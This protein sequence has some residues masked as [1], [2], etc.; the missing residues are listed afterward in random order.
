MQDGRVP[1]RMKIE[2][3]AM[4]F[5]VKSLPGCPVHTTTSAASKRVAPVVDRPEHGTPS[6]SSTVERRVVVE[7]PEESRSDVRR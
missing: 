4:R 7:E 5:R 3:L 6:I 1:T 2:P